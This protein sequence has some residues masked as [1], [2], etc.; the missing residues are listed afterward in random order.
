MG[1]NFCFDLDNKISSTGVIPTE[2][3]RKYLRLFTKLTTH[4]HSVINKNAIML[5]ILNNMKNLNRIRVHAPVNGIVEELF[6]NQVLVNS[7]QTIKIAELCK[8]VIPNIPFPKL[9]QLNLD[10]GRDRIL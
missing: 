1:N 9:T 5:L 8:L 4:M 6:I 2:Y 7:H 10:I 3:A